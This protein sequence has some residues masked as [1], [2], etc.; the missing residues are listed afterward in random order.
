MYWYSFGGG[1]WRGVALGCMSQPQLPWHVASSDVFILDFIPSFIFLSPP[2]T[3]LLACSAQIYTVASSPHHH[4]EGNGRMAARRRFSR[5]NVF[6]M[7]HSVAWWI[8]PFYYLVYLPLET[9]QKTR[10]FDCIGDQNPGRTSTGLCIHFDF[11]IKS[12]L[13]RAKK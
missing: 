10:C 13:Y 1:A 5:R 9:W 12:N 11:R 4:D 7:S 2:A 3:S 6:I 8:R